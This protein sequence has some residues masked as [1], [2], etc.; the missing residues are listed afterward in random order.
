MKDDY[1]G[2]DNVNILDDPFD[3]TG[4]DVDDPLE[5]T[6]PVIFCLATTIIIVITIIVATVDLLQKL[7]K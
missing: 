6:P 3:P 1:T 7:V 5:I 2:N 4:P